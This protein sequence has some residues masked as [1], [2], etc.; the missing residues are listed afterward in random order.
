TQYASSDAKRVMRR[1]EA[2]AGMAIPR[3]AR[4]RSPLTS[5]PECGPATGTAPS[6]ALNGSAAAGSI[7]GGRASA[8]TG[9]V[10]SGSLTGL[11]PGSP[12]AHHL[13]EC[14]RDLLRDAHQRLR[15]RRAWLG[16]HYRHAGV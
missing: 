12:G 9:W 11:P 2:T 16:G 4:E 14:D 3:T 7:S 8:G 15:C 5:A 10:M 13:V 1:L 6:R